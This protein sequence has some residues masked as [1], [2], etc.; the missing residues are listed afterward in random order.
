MYDDAD[1]SV[2]SIWTGIQWQKQQAEERCARI[3]AH[4]VARI[5]EAARDA[6]QHRDCELF[7]CVLTVKWWPDVCADDGSTWV[8]SETEGQGKRY[9]IEGRNSRPC[10]GIIR[11]PYPCSRPPYLTE[12]PPSLSKAEVTALLEMLAPTLSRL[13]SSQ[14]TRS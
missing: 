12:A 14:T 2:V 7:E 1:N 13:E 4:T 9:R 6:E 10:E 3:H 5:A 8:L 11:V